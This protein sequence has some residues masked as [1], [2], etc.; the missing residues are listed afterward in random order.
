MKKIP[1]AITPSIRPKNFDFV[2]SIFIITYIYWI[3]WII[4]Y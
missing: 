4:Y 3:Y 1:V 2:Q